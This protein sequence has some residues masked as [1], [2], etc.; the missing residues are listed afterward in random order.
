MKS[1][2]PSANLVLQV[3]ETKSTFLSISCS[4]YT[5]GMKYTLQNLY[6]NSLK[7]TELR[8]CAT[9]MFKNLNLIIKSSLKY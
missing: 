6:S 7:S 4:L 9:G 1:T 3:R 8:C 5:I 2:I